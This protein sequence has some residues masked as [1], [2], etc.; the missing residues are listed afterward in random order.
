MLLWIH[1]TPP[2]LGGSAR[3]DFAFGSPVMMSH[4]KDIAYLVGGLSDHNPLSLS[5]A[6]PAGGVKG[7]E[8]FARLATK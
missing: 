6:L 3:I 7:L 2:T 5:L 4:V 1:W 8:T